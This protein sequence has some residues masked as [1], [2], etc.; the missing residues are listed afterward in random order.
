MNVTRKPPFSSGANSS[1]MDASGG[2]SERMNVGRRGSGHVEEEDLILPTQH[3]QQATERQ[4]PPIAG[5][6]DVVRLVPD[7]A[8]ALASGTVRRTLP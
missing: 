1:V 4:R 6:P 2:L 8:G 7:R 5:E 3:A